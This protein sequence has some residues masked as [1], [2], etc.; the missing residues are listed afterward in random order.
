MIIGE[1]TVIRSAEPDDAFALW[2]LYDPSRPRSFLLGPAREVLI[3]TIDELREMLTRRDLVQGTFF[4]VEDK[5]GEVCGCCVLRG[6]K[7]ESEFAEMVIAFREDCEYEGPMAEE[8]FQ[9][10]LRMAF[11]DKKLNKIQ[12]H[13]LSCEHAYR[14]FLTA[15]GYT[16]DG[17]QRDMVYTKGK[18][19]D[20]ESLTLF[21]EA[22]L[23]RM[24]DSHDEHATATP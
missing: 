14:Q 5:T 18:Y 16:S 20:L 4:V 9:F 6:A 3:P 1:Y 8:I 22:G 23:S 12:A 15:R 24:K 19:F 10:I 17:I 11:V 13:C 21:R 7:L 2:R